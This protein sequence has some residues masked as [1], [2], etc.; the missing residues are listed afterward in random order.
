MKCPEVYL[1][2]EIRHFNLYVLIATYF[3]SDQ[4]ALSFYLKIIK[5]ENS[6]DLMGEITKFISIHHFY[7]G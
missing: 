1:P 3:K 7:R 5:N 4:P 2:D 6:I